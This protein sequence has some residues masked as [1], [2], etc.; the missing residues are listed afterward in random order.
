M[1]YLADVFRTAL[2]AAAT[3]TGRGTV[4]VEIFGPTTRRR[5]KR[6]RMGFK[7]EETRRGECPS[8]Q[9]VG[10]VGGAGARTHVAA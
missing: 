6:R 10:G 9:G 7:S 2:A 3:M 1:V 5:R 8:L 4:S